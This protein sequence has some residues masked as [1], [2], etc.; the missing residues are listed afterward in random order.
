MAWSYSGFSEELKEYFI[1]IPLSERN[2]KRVLI[3][4]IQ[5]L[6]DVHEPTR[7]V[8]ERAKALIDSGK[9][10]IIVNTTEQCITDG[11]MLVYNL[12]EGEV[13]KKY[14]NISQVGIGEYKVPF[15]QIPDNLT[16]QYKMQ[17]LAQII[18]KVKPYYILS[19]G[20]G[21]ILA[22]LCGNIVPCASMA[23]EF[24]TLPKTKN[25][26]KILGRKLSE[27]EKQLYIEEDIIESNG[28]IADIDHQ[29]CQRIE[30]N[31]W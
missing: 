28:V 11:Y 21:S 5:F 22:D 31:Y 18:N 3:L 15:L 19:V 23:L 2:K 17:V 7:T 20:T 8:K 10:V 12:F 24:S 26:M 27:E 6:E 14:N 9:D 1:K 30:E 29:I 25:K 4:T 16:L 13:L